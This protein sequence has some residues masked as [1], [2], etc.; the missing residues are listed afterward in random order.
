[1]DQGRE[2][3][4]DWAFTLKGPL[5]CFSVQAEVRVRT[6]CIRALNVMGRTRL[7]RIFT[8]SQMPIRATSAEWTTSRTVW[9][10]KNTINSYSTHSELYIIWVLVHVGI[11]GNER[12]NSFS[13]R[14]I[15]LSEISLVCAKPFD[16]IKS[17]LIKAWAHRSHSTVD[18]IREFYGA[19]QTRRK[20]ENR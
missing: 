6:E 14:A 13:S 4:R 9:D 2:K 10:W 1:M 5:N 3:R 19:I 17:E 16:A 15:E 7:V 18:S 12:A 8:D 11:T 20:R